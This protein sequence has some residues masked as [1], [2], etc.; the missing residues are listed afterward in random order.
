MLA[1][2]ALAVLAAAGNQLQLAVQLGAPRRAYYLLQGADPALRLT[3]G[4]I[5]ATMDG[6]KGAVLGFGLASAIRVGLGF[7]LLSTDSALLGGVRASRS[8]ALGET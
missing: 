5:G 1:A 3:F 4:V 8:E 7:V 2:V 6:M